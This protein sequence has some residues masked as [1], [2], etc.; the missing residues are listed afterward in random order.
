MSERAK[1]SAVKIPII[2]SDYLIGLYNMIEQLTEKV[3]QIS[4]ALNDNTAP[5]IQLPSAPDEVEI[6][7]SFLA[8]ALGISKTTIERRIADKKIPRP[9]M[10]TN[11]HYRYWFKYELPKSLHNKI[12]IHYFDSNKKLKTEGKLKRNR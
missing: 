5:V 7:L 9:R 1:P 11:N 4:T 2:T 8:H 3:D 12:D 6:S 10:N